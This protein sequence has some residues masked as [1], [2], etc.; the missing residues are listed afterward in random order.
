MR[1]A[2]VAHEPLARSLLVRLC[3]GIEGLEVIAQDGGV[4]Y[5]PTHTQAGIIGRFFR[6]GLHLKF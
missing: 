4:N 1:V 6:I 2:I 3:R 5:N